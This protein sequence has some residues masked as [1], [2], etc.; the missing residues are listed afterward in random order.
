MQDGQELPERHRR[1]LHRARAR[2]GLAEEV[3]LALRAD[4]RR[5]KLSQRAYAD[6][7]GMSRAMLARLEAGAG[8]L[9]LDTITSALLGTGFRLSLT[10]DDEP[11]TTPGAALL[12]VPARGCTEPD[13]GWPPTTAA[14][15]PDAWQPTDLVARVRGGSRRFPAHRRVYAVTNPPLWWWVQE[16]FDG[17]T[18]EPQWYSPVPLPELTLCRDSEPEDPE[19]GAA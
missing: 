5:L 1:Q 10:F 8:R 6:V 18:E 15:A 13:S 9:S 14:I 16:F 11:P 2:L 12:A 19:P 17:P 3:G 7:R 4:R